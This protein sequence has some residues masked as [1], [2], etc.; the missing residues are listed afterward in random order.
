MLNKFNTADLCYAQYYY[1]SNN[2]LIPCVFIQFEAE[3]KI[4][5]Y[6]CEI[7][8]RTHTLSILTNS[9]KTVSIYGIGMDVSFHMKRD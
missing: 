8:V 2:I 3:N 7:D 1:L 5:M 4:S 9:D 6:L